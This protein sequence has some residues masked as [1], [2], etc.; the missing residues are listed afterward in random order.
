MRVVPFQK[1]QN[2]VQKYMRHISKS[3]RVKSSFPV[4]SLGLNLF[5]PSQFRLVTNAILILITF[6]YQDAFEKRFLNTSGSTSGIKD[7]LVQYKIK[8]TTNFFGKMKL[9]AE[10]TVPL[11]SGIIYSNNA[12]GITV[13]HHFLVLCL[14][15]QVA[16]FLQADPTTRSPMERLQDSHE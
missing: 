12:R 7:E 1:Y 13:C 10:G 6:S 4:T 11:T 5:E 14:T 15:E 8:R 3:E 9:A 16:T 2:L